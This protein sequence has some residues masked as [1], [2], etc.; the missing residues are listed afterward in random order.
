MACSIAFKIVGDKQ[1]VINDHDYKHA[2]C[3]SSLRG[4]KL[5]G[6]V[7]AIYYPKLQRDTKDF[8]EKY[9]QELRNIGFELEYDGKEVRQAIPGRTAPWIV[10]SLIAARYV[11]EYGK[12]TRNFLWLLEQFP[13]LDKYEM[14]QLAH[15]V[16][17]N[18]EWVNTYGDYD[19]HSVIPLTMGLPAR[20]QR[21]QEVESKKLGVNDG[22]YMKVHR[23]FGGPSSERVKSR[24]PL[25]ASRELCLARH[26]ALG[27][28]KPT[29]AICSEP[30][31][32]CGA[33]QES[34]PSH[35]Q[36]TGS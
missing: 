7:V 27:G 15:Y 17:P 10:G 19:N 4:D 11:E 2:A 9:F 36:A 12:Y 33:V 31:V 32:V 35:D 24:N 34:V 1:Q 23:T 20:Y 5:T 21:W 28:E 29:E 13:T 18:S 16:E 3:F 30:V 22:Q 6:G 8:A 25:P 14:F 26:E